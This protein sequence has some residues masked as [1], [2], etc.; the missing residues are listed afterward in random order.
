MIAKD[1]V[2]LERGPEYDANCGQEIYCHILPKYVAKED[3][4][5]CYTEVQKVIREFVESERKAQA[6]TTWPIAERAGVT[7]GVKSVI[8]YLKNEIATQDSRTAG[9]PELKAHLNAVERC[10]L[11][12]VINALEENT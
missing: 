2:M 3:H 11:E 7:L 6:E 9:K 10:V 4:E 8:D 12:T 1:T 5:S